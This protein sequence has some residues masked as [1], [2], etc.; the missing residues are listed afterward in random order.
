MKR[1]LPNLNYR[2]LLF[3]FLSLILLGAV[4]YFAGSGL[5]NPEPLGKYLNNNF[6]ATVSISQGLPYVPIYPNLTFDSPLTFNELPNAQRILVGQRDGKIYWFNK[7]PDVAQ[8]NMLIDL[9]NKVGVVWDGGFLGLA[10]HPEF[11]TGAGKDY[12]YTFYTTKDVNGNNF[13][14]RYTTQNCTSEEYWGN[15]LILSRYTMNPNTMQ[16]SPS[17]EQILLK[18]RMYGTTHRGGGLL[19]GDD[20]FLYLTTGDQ[21]AFRKSQDIQNNLDGGVLRLDVDKDPLKSH[22]PV[23]NMPNDHG[24]FDEITGN[25][26]WIPN[27][28]PFLSPSGQNFEEYYSMGHRN[29]HRMTKDRATGDLYI[30]EVGLG[31]HEEINVVKKGGNFGWPVYEGRYKGNLCGNTLYNNM[32]HE[33]PLVA[34]PRSVANAIMGGYVYRG[35]EIPEL[36]G[37]YICADY[38]NGEEIFSVDIDTGSYEQLGSFSSTNIISFGE[39]KQGE[40]YILKQGVSTLYKLVTRMTFDETLPQALSQTG[41]FTNLNNLTP[42]NG[43]I[44]YDLVES[45]WSDGAAKK[46]WIGIPNDGTHNTPEEQ[47]DYSE[48]GNWNL[49][50]GSVLIKHFEMPL[51]ENNPSITKRLETRFSVKAADGNFYFATYK[52]NNAQTDAVL[53]TSGLDESLTI[54]RAD[55]T[56]DVQ[57]WRYPSRNE[58]ITCHNSSTG[59][60]IGTRT[61][62]LNKDLTYPATGRTANQLVTLSHLGILNQ[63]ITDADTPSLLTY[64]SANDPNATMDEKARSYMDLNCAYCHQAGSDVRADFDLRMSLDLAQTNLLDAD[65]FNS[66]GIPGERIIAEGEP[67]KSILYIRANSA[68]SNVSMP[69]LAKDRVDEEGVALI[70]AWI[71]QLGTVPVTNVSASP[72]EV[73]LEIGETV[74]PT[75]TIIPADAT[76]QGVSWLSDDSSIASVDPDSGLITAINE[77]TTSVTVTTDDG[78]YTASV[79]VTVNTPVVEIA[80]YNVLVSPK[81]VDLEVGETVQLIGA[82]E[83]L[84]ATN[85]NVSWISNDPTIA[86]ID[87]NGLVTAIGAGVIDVTVSAEDGGYSASA[88][89]TVTGGTPPDVAVY[90]ILVAPTTVSLEAGETVQLTATTEPANATNQNVSWI[91]NNPAIATIDSNGLVTAVGEGVIDVTVSAEDGGYSASSLITVTGGTPPPVSVYNILVA[92]NE[93]TLG[94][95]ETFQ[96]NASTEP[97]NATNQS[98]TW[99]SNNPA[100]ASVDTSG[101]VTATGLG[102]ID[103]TAVAD[104]GGYTASAIINVVASSQSSAVNVFPIPASGRVNVDL[105]EYEGQEVEI[106]LYNQ[107]NSL[108]ETFRIDQDH[109]DINELILDTYPSGYYYLLFQTSDSWST[110]PII[111]N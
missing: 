106:K 50:V 25:G 59:G 99:F 87:S 98:V 31:R 69:P 14:N 86:T 84:D 62:Y 20:G 57:N 63:T 71:T 9:S 22:P 60:T 100:I 102:E 11:D 105:A 54:T 109:Q 101:L 16:V 72:T 27:D 8:K 110:R 26:Y 32:A 80:V 64:K 15:F 83:P 55:G 107:N 39:D 42:T 3:A 90:N 76:D 37:R 85:Q 68:N 41:A 5:D 81:T 18:L 94:L 49:P 12:F 61:R 48:N 51:D 33:E 104:D 52:W 67:D 10:L 17:S 13:P 38:G 36:Q 21:T 19:F 75:A 95:G 89:I 30:G 7:T 4:P 73:S 23:K 93:V 40:M 46:R 79:S 88:I 74:L 58:C 111:I 108:L 2:K 45:F 28:N 96:L 6:P 77:G 78:G 91:S 43:L 24:F 34:F 1:K 92:P 35:S 82:V 65:I 47:I 70:E 53:L 66:L 44:P 103:V 56:T 29:P 97:S